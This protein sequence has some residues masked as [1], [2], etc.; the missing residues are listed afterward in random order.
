MARGNGEAAQ[1]A[2]GYS[3]VNRKCA[4]AVQRAGGRRFFRCTQEE[5]LTA[6]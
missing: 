5:F 4:G 2:A 6:S 1:G 3:T